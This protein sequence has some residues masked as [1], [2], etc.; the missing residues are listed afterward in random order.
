MPN[1]AL[2]TDLMVRAEKRY[3]NIAPSN[4]PAN[5]SGSVKEI[6]ELNSRPAL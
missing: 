2:P 1:A 5:I 3:G 6:R 4:N